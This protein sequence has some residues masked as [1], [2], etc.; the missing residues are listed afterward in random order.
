M[1][2][3]PSKLRDFAARYAEAWC[4]GVP[5]RVAEFYTPNGSLAINGGPASNGRRAITE[6]ARGF[7]QSF[8]DMKVFMDDLLIRGDRAEFHWTLDGHNTGPGGTGKRVRISGF[9][10][11]TIGADG[12]I[13]ASQGNF[14]AAEYE[15]QL[16]H[17][18]QP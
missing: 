6:A 1:T 3:D 10:V 18:Y 14:D 17:G 8:P 2:L 16:Q 7:M 11:W 12:L 13:A 5:Q 4:S 15:R 9:E